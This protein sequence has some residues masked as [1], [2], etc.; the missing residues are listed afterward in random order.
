MMILLNNQIVVLLALL[1]LVVS[2][3]P[4]NNLGGKKNVIRESAF[5]V[6]GEIFEGNPIGKFI[7]DQVWKLP[8]MK[9]GKPGTSPTTFGDNAL[10]LKANILQLYGDQPSVDGAPIA[11]GEMGRFLEGS[12]FLG[13]QQ[14]YNSFGGVY[15]LLMGPKSFIV[16]SDPAVMKHILRDNAKAYDKGVLAEI[17]EPIMGQGLIPAKPETA[18]VRRRAI[19]PGFHKK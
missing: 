17:L 2:F 4:K 5:I 9:P 1:P 12:A 13:L 11:E 19:L 6:K 10:V 3:F 14:F 15:K 7:W 8:I 18:I 16:V